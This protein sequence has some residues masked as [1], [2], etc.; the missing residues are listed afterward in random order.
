[1]EIFANR[2]KCNF[3]WLDC[4]SEEQDISVFALWDTVIAKRLVDYDGGSDLGGFPL[5]RPAMIVASLT[6]VA[7]Y[8]SRPVAA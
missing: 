1:M 8:L 7:S 5:R 2:A 4:C 3:S 6:S